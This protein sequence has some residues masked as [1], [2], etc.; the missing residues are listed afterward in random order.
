MA[1]GTPLLAT[2]NGAAAAGVNLVTTD[3]GA[4]AAEVNVLHSPFCE[5]NSVKFLQSN[6]D[7]PRAILSE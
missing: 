2:R 6:F 5:I 3:N 7:L 4:A 1:W